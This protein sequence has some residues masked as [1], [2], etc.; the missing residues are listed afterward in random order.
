MHVDLA[1]KTTFK[2]NNSKYF[3][4]ANTVTLVNYIIAIKAEVFWKLIQKLK[5]AFPFRS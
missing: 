3:F 2:L 5:A 1:N 4:L